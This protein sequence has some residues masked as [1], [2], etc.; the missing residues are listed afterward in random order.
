MD[1]RTVISIVVTVL[2]VVSVGCTTAGVTPGYTGVEKWPGF[3]IVDAR[4]LDAQI[5]LDG[6][7]LGTARELM[8][9]G[10]PVTPGTHALQ[11]VRPGFRPFATH[12]SAN[13]RAYPAIIRV[14]LVPA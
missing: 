9:L 4:P 7:P 3:L 14:T 8:A 13:P 2:M 6:K 12:F 10:L 11:I 5:F 1:R